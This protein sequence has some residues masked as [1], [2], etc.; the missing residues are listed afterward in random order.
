MN[1]AVIFDIKPEY[2]NLKIDRTGYNKPF[3]YSQN[4]SGWNDHISLRF[5]EFSNEYNT[6]ISS[7]AIQSNLLYKNV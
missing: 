6:D 4:E 1:F 7:N 2:E 3:S 5:V